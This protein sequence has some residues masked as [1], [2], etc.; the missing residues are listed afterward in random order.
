MTVAT[1]G[2]DSVWGDGVVAATAASG[3]GLPPPTSSVGTPEVEGHQKD[4]SGR[5]DDGSPSGWSSLS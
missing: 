4:I 2:A 5:G 1:G 3:S